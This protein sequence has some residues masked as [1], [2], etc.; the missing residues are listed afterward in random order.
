MSR[1]S[2]WFYTKEGRR[3]TWR[4]TV[5][6]YFDFFQDHLKENCKYKLD[7]KLREELEED[8]YTFRCYDPIN[9]MFNDC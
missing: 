3:E 1:Y 2:R 4:E 5:T 8:R 9:E 7:S 6:R